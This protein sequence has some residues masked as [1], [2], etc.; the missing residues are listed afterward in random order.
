VCPDILRIPKVKDPERN[1]KKVLLKFNNTKFQCSQF[2]FSDKNKKNPSTGVKA[3]YRVCK[4]KRNET[5]RKKGI[6]FE[7]KRNKKSRAKKRNETK[8]I[9]KRNETKKI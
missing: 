9:E 2:C 3:D 4:T 1:G 8:K 5:K 6:N 7:T